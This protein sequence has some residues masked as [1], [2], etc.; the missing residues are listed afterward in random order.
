MNRYLG[1][2]SWVP[3]YKI[4]LIYTFLYIVCVYSYIFCHCIFD[5]Y[6]SHL[7]L[8]AICVTDFFMFI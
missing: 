8:Y 7:F 3:I 4:Y 6:I 5:I 1:I 2:Q